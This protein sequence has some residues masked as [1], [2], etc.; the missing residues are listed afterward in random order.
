[1]RD[2]VPIALG[3]YTVAFSLGIIARKA[4]LSPVVG[5]L[6]SLLTRA[7]AGEYGVYSLV[8]L[9]AAYVEVV[10]MCVVANLRYLLMTTALA[11][12][13]PAGMS[14]WHKLLTASCL[15]DEM[16]GISIAYGPQLNPWYT[17]GASAMAMPLWALGTM[18]GIVAGELLPPFIVESLSVALYGMFIAI[19]VPPAKR[20]RAVAVGIVIS[21]LASYAASVLPL[22]SA[23]SG[24]M[25][26]IILTIAISS[27]LAIVAPRRA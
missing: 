25:R 26:T 11:Q 4:G 5:F 21:F 9:Q 1:M 12:K 7:S 27:V 10:A 24:G 3:Y 13:F 17:Y 6:G 15:T 2:A 14:L 16:F 20:D 19:I 23:I 18:S 22:V 8:I